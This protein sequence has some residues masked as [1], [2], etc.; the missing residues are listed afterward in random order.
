MI[1]TNGENEEEVQKTPK[2]RLHC[3]KAKNVVNC[4]LLDTSYES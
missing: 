3:G 4:L 2:V 1:S